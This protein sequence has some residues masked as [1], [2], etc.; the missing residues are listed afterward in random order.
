MIISRSDN[1]K[2]I[3]AC[4][5]DQ[6]LK[7]RKQ[8]NAITNQLSNISDF[9]NKLITDIKNFNQRIKDVKEI[10]KNRLDDIKQKYHSEGDYSQDQKIDSIKEVLDEN[11]D[12]LDELIDIVADCNMIKNYNT[13]CV[14]IF[15]TGSEPT[16]NCDE[17]HMIG[18]GQVKQLVDSKPQMCDSS[19][20]Q[21]CDNCYVGEF[22]KGCGQAQQIGEG[23]GNRVSTTCTSRDTTCTSE[24]DANGGVCLKGYSNNQGKVVC[25]LNYNSDGITCPKNYGRATANPTETEINCDGGFHVVGGDTQI[26]CSG[27]YSSCN[28]DV[29]TSC[30]GDYKMYRGGSLDESCNRN[31]NTT[32]QGGDADVHTCDGQ[33]SCTTV[34]VSCDKGEEIPAPEKEP[35]EKGCFIF[36]G[37]CFIFD[38]GSDE[39]GED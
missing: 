35:K 26:D 33:D 3:N 32:C 22:I 23:C 10:L 7:V 12:A 25:E 13:G 37:G 8:I 5:E 38:G 4:L 14:E 24:V 17:F 6:D 29:A 15:T 9:L 39:G 19:Q 20:A 28:S 18:C 27:V 30:S 11:N 21:Y 31:H 36:D 16:I 1:I 34:C 2:N